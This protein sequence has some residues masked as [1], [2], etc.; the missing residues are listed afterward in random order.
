MAASTIVIH[1]ANAGVL[2]I[3]VAVLG[4]VAHCVSLKDKLD[5]EVPAEL[6]STG[7]SLLFWPAC[8][9][10]IDF[11]LFIF[12]W[13]KTTSKNDHVSH[14]PQSERKSRRC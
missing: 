1:T 4:L 8:G 11:C 2:C 6:K 14:L 12:L 10:I 7:M 3:S 9:G 5:Y 13:F